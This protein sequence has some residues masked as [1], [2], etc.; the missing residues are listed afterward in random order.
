MFIGRNN[1]LEQLDRLYQENKFQCIIIWGRR[2]VGKTTLINEFIKDKEAIYFMAT[3]T[4]PQENL[5]SFSASIASINGVPSPNAPVYQSYEQALNAIGELS[6]QKQ[7]VLVIDEYPYLA[8]SYKPISSILQKLIDLRLKRDSKLFIILCGSSMSFM[9]KQVLGY[10]S[11]LYGRRT[12][13]LQIMPFD[14]Y[15]YKHYFQHFTN[16]DLA[17]VY[18]ITGGIPQYM[19][20]FND[21]LSIK[22]NIIK[23]FLTPS[24]YLLEEPENLMQQ[25]MRQPAIYNAII[26]AI[27]NGSSKNAEICSKVG[28]ESSALAN[29]LEKLL[30]LGIIMKETPIGSK[31]SR[32]TIYTIKDNLFRFWYRFIPN[33]IALIQRGK[34]ENAWNN[35]E[36]LLGNYM[37]KVFEDICRDYLW[38]QYD[39]L[40]CAF[41]EIGRWWGPNPQLKR[42]EEV[43]IVAANADSAIVAECKWRNEKTDYDVVETLLLRAKLLPYKHLYYYIFSKSGFTSKCT[44]LAKEQNIKLISYAEMVSD[45]G[46]QLN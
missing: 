28:L 44:K 22:D 45:V 8:K 33:N 30:E 25:E 36:G 31:E 6:L 41:Q 18:G 2:R 24:G 29:Y 15:E 19:S 42:Q 35:I 14:F 43:D 3:D 12:G 16:E 27:A 32:K 46:V 20:F 10:Q 39:K 34:A 13:Q 7:I 23:N 37:G 11:P 9:E 21:K 40:P 26:K 1:E 5:I 38:Q 4:T 17:I